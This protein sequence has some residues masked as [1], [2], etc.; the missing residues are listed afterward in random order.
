MAELNYA[1]YMKTVKK[2][3]AAQNYMQR[4]SREK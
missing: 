2:Y 4:E 1:K 3:M